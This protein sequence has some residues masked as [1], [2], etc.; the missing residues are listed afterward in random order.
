M[1]FELKT[2]KPDKKTVDKTYKSNAIKLSFGTVR[3]FL[4]EIPIEEIDITNRKQIAMI[5][6][7]KWEQIVP[8]FTDI[9]PGLTEDE[10]DTCKI[11]DMGNVVMGVFAYMTTEIDSLIGGSEKN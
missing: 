8:L 10:L 4:K 3:G 2:Y 11:D 6:L 9:F 5:L 1:R 7:R